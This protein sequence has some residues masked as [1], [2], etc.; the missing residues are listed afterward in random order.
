MLKR[1]FSTLAVV[2]LSL[3]VFSCQEKGGS[4][5]SS[6]KFKV[7]PETVIQDALKNKKFLIVIFESADCKYCNKLNKEVLSDL[8]FKQSAIK[9][10]VDIAI[11]NVYG[12]REVTDPETGKKMTEEALALAYR[13]QGYPT[14]N[15]FDP[16]SNFKLLYQIPGYIPKEDFISLLNFLGSKCYQKVRYQDFMKKGQKC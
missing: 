10:N 5:A 14:I 9:N 16:D 3:V 6:E 12:Q 15:V 7:N 13:V 4:G 11:V 8:D 1:L 2:F